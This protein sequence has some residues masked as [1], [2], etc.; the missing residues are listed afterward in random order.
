MHGEQNFSN[1]F[2]SFIKLKF[3]FNDSKQ[4]ANFSTLLIICKDLK[5]NLDCTKLISVFVSVPFKLKD[6]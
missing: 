4:T 6:I 5:A 1:K 3:A 2:F